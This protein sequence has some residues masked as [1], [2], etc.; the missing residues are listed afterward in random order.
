[1][2][3]A[4]KACRVLH[5]TLIGF[6]GLTFVLEMADVGILASIS[7]GHLV[8]LIAWGIGADMDLGSAPNYYPLWYALW[9]FQVLSLIYF[10]L[11]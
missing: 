1:M 2:P 6:L 5:G 7:G 3:P 9:T 10:L 8:L 11:G 4:V